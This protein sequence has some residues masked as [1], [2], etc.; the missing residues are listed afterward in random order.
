MFNNENRSLFPN[1]FVNARLLV[2]EKTGVTLL[3]TAAIQRNTNDT[4]VYLVKPDNTVTVRTITTGDHRRRPVRDHFGL[5]PGDTGRDDR[6][7]QAGGRQQGHVPG[8]GPA[9]VAA[10]PARHDARAQ[11]T[12]E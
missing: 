2:Q 3:P 9:P 5:E 4:Y 8:G 11:D 1:Q 7:G 12:R 6:C 10:P